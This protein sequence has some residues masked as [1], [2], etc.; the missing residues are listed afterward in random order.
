MING[1]ALMTK[2]LVAKSRQNLSEGTYT[3]VEENLESANCF[4]RFIQAL[5]LEVS[6]VADIG[7]IS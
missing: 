6:D 3:I 4:A 5:I 2:L 7:L 1:E